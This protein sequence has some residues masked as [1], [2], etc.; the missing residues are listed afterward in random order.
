[1][2]LAVR[3]V[4]AE[5]AHLHLTVPAEFLGAAIRVIEAWGFAYRSVL[6][7]EGLPQGYGAYWRPTHEF[8]LLGVRGQI[9]F[10]DNSLVGQVEVEESRAV[11][12]LET[13]RELIER[14]SPGPYL[15]VFGHGSRPGWTV[16]GEAASGIRGT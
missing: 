13:L 7:L 8:L 11:Q 14:V 3:D 4:A 15:E 2:R 10:R 5:Q 1:M 6:V 16:G 12:R 9:P